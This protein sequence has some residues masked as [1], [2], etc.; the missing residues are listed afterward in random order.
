MTTDKDTKQA[1]KEPGPPQ[2]PE[3]PDAGGES[4]PDT[5]RA[6]MQLLRELKDAFMG[7]DPSSA[8]LKVDR[9][10]RQ[11]LAAMDALADLVEATTGEDMTAA[12]KVVRHFER[13]FLSSHDA[14][15][16]LM[17]NLSRPGAP[18]KTWIEKLLRL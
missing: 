18:E 1:K 16:E 4:V 6:K 9:G 14:L 12:R 5:E 3:A 7:K 15:A 10:V 11:E 8:L 17:D 13:S 2:P